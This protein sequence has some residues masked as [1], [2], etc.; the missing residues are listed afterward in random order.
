MPHGDYSRT[1]T[2]SIA[3]VPIEVTEYET[4]PEKEGSF[5]REETFLAHANPRLRQLYTDLRAEGYNVGYSFQGKYPGASRLSEQHLNNMEWYF[6]NAP[7]RAIMDHYGAGPDESK[8]GKAVPGYLGGGV[9]ES[10]S[11]TGERMLWYVPMAPSGKKGHALKLTPEQVS[12]NRA[13]EM[14]KEK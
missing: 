13:R 8:T 3:G 7:I 10:Y 1:F 5:L 12:K 11:S 2:Y 4:T 9:F 14:G 6:E